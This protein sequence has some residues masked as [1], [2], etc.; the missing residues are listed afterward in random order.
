[1]NEI[2]NP[3]QSTTEFYYNFKLRKDKRQRSIK[4][5]HDLY[6][7]SK[8]RSESRKSVIWNIINEIVE[9]IPPTDYRGTKKY[10]TYFYN[11]DILYQY[12]M[13]YEKEWDSYGISSN[14]VEFEGT[15]EEIRNQTINF[16][17]SEDL[18]FELGEKYKKNQNYNRHIHRRVMHYLSKAIEKN[19]EEIYKDVNYAELPRVIPVNIGNYQYIF[20]VDLNSSKYYKKFTFIGEVEIDPIVM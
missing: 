18:T 9:K 11:N 7:R 15:V 1:M 2:A 3:H 4:E 5:I 8:N 12:E 14:R 10:I 6:I 19:L 17:I 13:T 20:D 16:V